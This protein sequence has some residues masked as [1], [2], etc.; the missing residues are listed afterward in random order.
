MK[1]WC[2]WLAVLESLPPPGHTRGWLALAMSDFYRTGL[3]LDWHT[4]DVS[5]LCHVKVQTHKFKK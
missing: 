4:V 2:E 3:W 1:N 5:A